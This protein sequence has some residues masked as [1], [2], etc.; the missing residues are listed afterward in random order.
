[1]TGCTGGL[2]ET[3]ALECVTVDCSVPFAARAGDCCGGACAG[4]TVAVVYRDCE[5]QGVT[6]GA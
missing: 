6:A 5:G 3:G 1:M 2:H 4:C